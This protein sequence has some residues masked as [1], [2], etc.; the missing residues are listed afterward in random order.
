MS[1]KSLIYG[2]SLWVLV[3]LIAACEHSHP[4]VEAVLQQADALMDAH[5]DSAFSL[6]DSLH[7]R[8]PM[9]RQETARYALLLAKATNKTYHPLLPCDSLLDISLS[10]YKKSTPERAT[11]LLYKGRLEEELGQTGRAIE[12]LQSSLSIIRDYPNEKEI[13]RHLLSSLGIL[14]EDNKH[15]EESLSAFRKMLSV[16]D[17]DKDKAIAFRGISKYYVMTD[18]TDSA[19][20]YIKEALQCSKNANDSILIPQMEHNLALYYYYYSLPDSALLMEREA[21][22]HAVNDT[23]R[24]LYYG[25]YGAILYDLNQIDSAVYY[26]N[27]SIDTTLFERH[28]LTTLLNLYQTLIPQHFSLT[29]FISS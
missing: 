16:C 10:Y 2:F 18:Q 13:K 24:R 7:Y 11:A 25:T 1:I 20:Y 19:F 21:I 15:F 4:Q 29:I 14:Y 5:P 22:N 26:L 3:V 12:L 23:K 9:S 8:Q 6:L 27:A 17:A 28:R